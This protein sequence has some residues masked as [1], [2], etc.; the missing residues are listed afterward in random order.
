MVN[1]TQNYGLTKDIKPQLDSTKHLESGMK[2][3]CLP[4][5]I[6]VA[7]IKLAALADHG[8]KHS[9]LN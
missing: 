9:A 8:R 5:E 7:L 1:V 2:R 4:E 3:L 6:R